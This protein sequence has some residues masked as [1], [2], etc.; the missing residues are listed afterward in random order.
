M[1][2]YLK[3]VVSFLEFQSFRGLSCS[4][5]ATIVHLSLYLSFLLGKEAIGAV[6]MAFAALKWVHGIL[7]LQQSPLDSSLCRN[8]VETEKR[9]RKR[10]VIKKAPATENL[11]KAIVQR[12]GQDQAN[13]KDLRLVTMCVLSFAG[14]FRAKELLC[15]RLRDIK[16]FQDYFVINVPQSKTD[17]YR[18]GQDVFIYKSGKETCPGILL[19]R[20]LRKAGIVL[21]DSTDYLFRNVIYL[22][23]TSSYTLGRRAVSYGRFREM[24][25]ACL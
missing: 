3:E 21:K 1:W 23:S 7:P 9:Q 8:L 5:P 15:I 13:L 19:H 20:Y 16:W 11:I 18:K 17:V 2:R 14:L 4:F 12:F 10:P 22:K 24:F 25:K 6:S